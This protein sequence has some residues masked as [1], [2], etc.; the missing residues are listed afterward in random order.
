MCGSIAKMVCFSDAG[1]IVSFVDFQSVH[2]NEQG[3][4]QQ[5]T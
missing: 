4:H 2:W 1:E 3:A 5:K